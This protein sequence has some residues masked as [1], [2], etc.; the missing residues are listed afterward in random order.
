[1]ITNTGDNDNNAANELQQI[2]L[3][4]TVL[5]LSQNGGSVTLPSSGGGDNWGTQTAVSDGITLSGNG[6]ST[7]PIKLANQNAQ[8]G[9]VLKSNGST[10][11]PGADNDQQTLAVSGQNLSISNGN[12]V[13]IPQDGDGS[14][15][16]EIQTLSLSG[17]NLTLSQNGGSVT[18][19]D[20]S[21]T[22]EIQALSLAGQDLTLSNGGVQ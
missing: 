16:N 2:T 15:T 8:N 6:T 19:P 12:S 4:G 21:A 17:A 3:S 10:W 7:N 5:T 14:A 20:A 11:I 22:N 13:A 9:Q 1:M 18:L